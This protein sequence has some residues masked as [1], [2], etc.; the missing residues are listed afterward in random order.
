MTRLLTTPVTPDLVRGVLDTEPRPDGGIVPHRLP[1]AARALADGQLAT[2]ESQTSG[3]RI[4]FTSAATVIEL[5]TL[6]T[7]LAYVGAPPRPP[8][9]YDLLIDRSPVA[10]GTV[11]GGRTVTTDMMTGAAMVEEGPTGTVRFRGLAPEPKEIEIWL[12]WNE[13]TE[14]V[15]LRTDAPVTPV[16]DSGRR[17]WLHHGS[18]V[19]HGSVS[20]GPASTWVATAA[21]RAGVDPVNLGFSGSALLDPFTARAMRDT[22]ADLISVKLGINL[23][24]T[25]LMRRRAL[26]PAV[27]GF[28]DLIRDGHPE[29]PLLVV[30]P[31]LC[32]IHEETPG[33][34]MPDLA[35]MAEGRISFLASGDPAEVAAGKL[36]LSVIREELARIVELRAGADPRIGYLDGREL[37]GEADAE[38]QPLPDAV[39]PSAV[40]QRSMG[41]RFAGLAFGPGGIFAAG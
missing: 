40:T 27:H 22:S 18:S 24:N 12:P 8:G 17:V 38:A 32:P 9:V 28:L 41:E 11:L 34:L 39:H 29:T 33:P 26:A 13:A 6:P 7:R 15:A 5:E 10:S 14:L 23:V 36:T 20:D 19:S 37:Y 35:G 16:P 2:A 1:A 4:V 21:I 30:S 31:V 3:V 25:D